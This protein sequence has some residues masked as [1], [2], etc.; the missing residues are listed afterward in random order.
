MHG[1]ITTQPFICRWCSKAYRI[2]VKRTGRPSKFCSDQC[3]NRHFR[4]S[5]GADPSYPTGCNETLL[6]NTASAEP[7]NRAFPDRPTVDKALWLKIVR[8]ERGWSGGRET[9]SSG[10]VPAFIVRER[11]K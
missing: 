9:V 6:K 10:G 4:Y 11:Q 8:A 2:S 5:N 3:R 7:C 1:R